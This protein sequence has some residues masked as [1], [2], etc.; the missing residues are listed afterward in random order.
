MTDRGREF[1]GNEFTRLLKDWYRPTEG[2][3]P[4]E[5]QVYGGDVRLVIGIVLEEFAVMQ[6][7]Y[8]P[9]LENDNSFQLVPGHDPGH[10]MG[11]GE[12]EH[13]SRVILSVYYE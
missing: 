13:H 1:T 11:T 4:D 9:L 3:V 6:A 8:L 12:Q 5:V 10:A 2:L 7:N